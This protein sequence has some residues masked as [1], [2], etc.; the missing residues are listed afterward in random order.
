[1][2]KELLTIIES[3][4]EKFWVMTAHDEKKAGPFDTELAADTHLMK[5]RDKYPGEETNGLHVEQLPN[6]LTDDEKMADL[7]R[8]SKQADGNA[9]LKPQAES[10]EEKVSPLF[11]PP[12]EALGELE[13]R[14]AAARKGLGLANRLKDKVDKKKHL[15]AVLKNM[16]S[17]RASLNQ[18][19]KQ[20]EMYSR[21]E[22]DYERKTD[23][24]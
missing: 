4:K 23:L 17:I 12:D 5:L 3:K 7:A 8:R 21:A 10:L 6:P 11:L 9:W 14:M 22:H 15:S 19:I 1:M 16:N 24:E 20:I 13:K 18:A 2:L